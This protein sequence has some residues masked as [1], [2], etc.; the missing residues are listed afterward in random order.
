[1]IRDIVDKIQA[2]DDLNKEEKAPSDKES[3]APITIRLTKDEK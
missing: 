3:E 2:I 1:M